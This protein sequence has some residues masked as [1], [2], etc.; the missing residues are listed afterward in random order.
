M[1]ERVL[2][3]KRSAVYKINVPA[4]TDSVVSSA[5]VWTLYDKRQQTLRAILSAGDELILG[6]FVN[7]TRFR[8]Q[9]IGDAIIE[10]IGDDFSIPI[11]LFE[12]ATRSVENPT[13]IDFSDSPYDVVHTDQQIIVDSR[14]GIPIINMLPLFIAPK[15]NLD[16]KRKRDLTLS[17]NTVV[18]HGNEVETIEQQ[19]TSEILD[20]GT[21]L[22]YFPAVTDWIIR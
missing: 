16:I 15:R 14:G 7:V 10:E 1:I 2:H 4:V 9:T 12:Y 3:I 21:N 5:T 19:L 6:P 11:P 18:V 22:T 8:I 13:E 20:T 17:D